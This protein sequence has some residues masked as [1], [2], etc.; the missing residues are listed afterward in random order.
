MT[1]LVSALGVMLLSLVVSSEVLP[2]ADFNLQAVSH[3]TMS[4]ISRLYVGGNHNGNL[5][6]L[7]IVSFSV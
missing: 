2:P 1:S 4:T 6:C 7:H 5:W 3:I